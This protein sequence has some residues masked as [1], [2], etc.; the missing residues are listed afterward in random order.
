MK[1]LL[2][3][4]I[5]VVIGISSVLGQNCLECLPEGDVTV[6]NILLLNTPSTTSRLYFKSS[7]AEDPNLGSP[8]SLFNNYEP[9]KDWKLF[10]DA[11]GFYIQREQ[12]G[13]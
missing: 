11:F 2:L 7:L 5:S 8:F 3:L 10:S 1:K 4:A 9:G 13:F 6:G 12:N